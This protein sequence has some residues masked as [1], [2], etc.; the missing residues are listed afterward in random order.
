MDSADLLNRFTF[1]PVKDADQG[2]LY[3][4]IRDQALALALWLDE[5]VPDS[6][7]LSLAMTHLEEVVFWSNAAVARNN[8]GD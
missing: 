2:A 8:K 5:R 3:G 1:H 4:S 6:R 7:E